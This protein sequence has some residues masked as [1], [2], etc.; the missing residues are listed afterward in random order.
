M[1]RALGSGLTVLGDRVT[2]GNMNLP[3]IGRSYTK[4]ARAD[5]EER[6]REALLDA[7]DSAFFSGRWEQTSL[8]EMAAAAGVT[9]QTLFRHFGAK[10]GLLEQAARRGMQ[11]VRDQRWS[12]PTRDI[13]GAVDN[14]LDHYE[15]VG[16]RAMRIAAGSGGSGGQA[17]D[18]VGRVARQM[19][20]DWVDYAFGSWLNHVRGKARTRRRAALIALCDV[21]TWWL[22]S[23]DLGLARA[24]LRATLIQA[25]RSLLEEDA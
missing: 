11:R 4:K 20:Y 2:V 7:A 18:A 14:L 19:H 16:E 10:Q 25:I 5:G 6:T 8:T 1:D 13:S 3:P 21:H 24:E 9:K 17:I 15:E 12:A 23:H 22:L